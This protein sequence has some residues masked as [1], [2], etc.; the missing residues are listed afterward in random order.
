M[1]ECNIQLNKRKKL[2]MTLHIGV[3]S[4]NDQQ[5]KKITRN[6]IVSIFVIDISTESVNSLSFF[7]FILKYM[8]L[9]P[10]STKSNFWLTQLTFLCSQKYILSASTW[11]PLGRSVCW[12]WCKLAAWCAALSGKCRRPPHCQSGSSLH[13]YLKSCEWRGENCMAP[14]LPYKPEHK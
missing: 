10:V 14:Q 2:R 9:M 5:I 4:W 13:N 8:K 7:M 6:W 1:L 11:R 12:G 3:N